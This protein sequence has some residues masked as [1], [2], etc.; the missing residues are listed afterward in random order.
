MCTVIFVPNPTLGELGLRQS[1]STWWMIY[2]WHCA[3]AYV[4]KRWHFDAKHL[5]T[6]LGVK[7]Q[8]PEIFSK[9]YNNLTSFAFWDF[10]LCGIL[11]Y[12][13]ILVT[14]LFTV[15]FVFE[16]VFIFYGRLLFK[17]AFIL[18]S[19]SFLMFSLFLRIYFLSFC[20]HFGCPLHFW[21]F[22]PSSA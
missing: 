16:A 12:S 22:F 20:L 14:C 4:R 13:F 6:G 11:K 8:M 21:G 9:R 2:M 15:I 7:D 17:V 1:N 10:L 3:C 19:H 18:K 5:N